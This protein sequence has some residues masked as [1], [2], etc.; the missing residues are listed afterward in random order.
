M[1]DNDPVTRTRTLARILGPFLF[2]I[3]SAVFLRLEAFQRLAPNL[4]SDEAAML[5]LGIFSL[6][7]GLAIF[8][9]HHHWSSAAAIAVSLLGIVT[10]VRGT[11]LLLTPQ[12]AAGF[13]EPLLDSSLII[14]IAAALM[15][16]LGAW[17]TFVGWFERKPSPLATA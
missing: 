16:V 4:L 2:V 7:A 11:L 6:A 5:I 14:M 15:L 12:V 1:V 8:T 17:L 3:A 9:A 10:I 13:A